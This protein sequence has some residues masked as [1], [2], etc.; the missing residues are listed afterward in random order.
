MRRKISAQDQLGT[1]QMN[2]LVIVAGTLAL[3]VCAPT[4]HTV[5]LRIPGVDAK[6]VS[7][8]SPASG[9][10]FDESETLQVWKSNGRHGWEKDV[11]LGSGED[12]AGEATYSVWRAG[13]WQA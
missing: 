7:A 12:K 5:L 1:S 4:A 2:V 8:G 11:P 3:R 10:L 9:S 6:L 13:Q